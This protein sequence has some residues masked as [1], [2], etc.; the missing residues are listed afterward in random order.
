M[1]H[2]WKE[3]TLPAESTQELL[4]IFITTSTSATIIAMLLHYNLFEGKK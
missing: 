1:N 3:R 2:G 4:V